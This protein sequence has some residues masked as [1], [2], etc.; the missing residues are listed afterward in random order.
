[1]NNPGLPVGKLIFKV[2]LASKDQGKPKNVGALKSTFLKD[3][4]LH[5]TK[6][7]TN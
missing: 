7:S 6:L 5:T 1:M 3:T 4:V 2:K